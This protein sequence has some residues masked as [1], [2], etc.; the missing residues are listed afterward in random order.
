M[1]TEAIYC[2]HI[3]LFI[4]L[5]S[6]AKIRGLLLIM[7]FCFRYHCFVVKGHFII[8]FLS[9]IVLS[10][11]DCSCNERPKFEYCLHLYLS[12]LLTDIFKITPEPCEGGI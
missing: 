5:A 9:F 11:M 1:G 12:E 6:L 8:S 2:D 3:C 7:L 4:D 10:L